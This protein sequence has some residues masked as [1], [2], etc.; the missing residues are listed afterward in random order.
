MKIQKNNSIT[1]GSSVQTGDPQ[2]LRRYIMD[3][4]DKKYDILAEAKTLERLHKYQP[5]DDVNI[6]ARYLL[7]NIDSK[8]KEFIK[9]IEEDGIEFAALAEELDMSKDSLKQAIR[10]LRSKCVII[11]NFE[12]ERGGVNWGSPIE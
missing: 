3:M 9:Y 10:W 8:D 5:K 1:E 11:V 2:L 12:S 7:G 6:F 4:Q